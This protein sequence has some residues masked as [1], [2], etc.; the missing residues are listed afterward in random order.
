M[1]YMVRM[2]PR[3]PTP[4]EQAQDFWDFVQR[5]SLLLGLLVTVRSL[6]E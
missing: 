1:Q 4:E 6:F 5:L 3:P 2:P